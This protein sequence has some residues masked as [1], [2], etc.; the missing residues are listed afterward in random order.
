[1]MPRI[2][3]IGGS[4]SSGGAGVQ[5]DVKT[6][7]ALGGYAATV[8][9]AL[10]AQNTHEI[11]DIFDVDVYF[12]DQQL[13]AVLGDVG[14]DVIKLGMLRNYRV[15]KAVAKRVLGA[16]IPLVLDPVVLSS[17]GSELLDKRGQ[18]ALVE[19]LLPH[20]A[21]L[22]PNIPEA[23][24]LT[25]VA[26]ADL[27]GMRLAADYLLAMGAGAV[28]VKGGHLPPPQES[29]GEDNLVDVL[30]TADGEESLFYSPRQFNRHTHG[31]GCTFASAIATGIAEG[32]TLRDAVARAQIY[33][34]GAIRHAPGI[35]GGIGPLNH[36]HA[37]GALEKDRTS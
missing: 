4:D 24:L 12:I 9:T 29:G 23:Q 10:T 6:I 26:I 37:L 30:R 25:G 28:V 13:E 17:S 20:V 35:G 2:L 5:A 15:V 7:T 33:V 32:L 19:Q 22:T 11:A 34:A 1:M 3:A 18:Q 21:V 14:A 16:G 8:V 27:D 36:C 31:T